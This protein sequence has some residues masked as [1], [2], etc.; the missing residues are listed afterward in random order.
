MGKLIPAIALLVSACASPYLHRNVVAACNEASSERHEI[1]IL[2][3]QE[4][5]A[6]DSASKSGYAG[7]IQRRQVQLTRKRSRC[8]S[9]MKKYHSKGAPHLWPNLAEPPPPGREDPY[10]DR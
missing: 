2:Q 9:L 3:A 5:M 1:S 10:R 6:A 8:D 7:E 4:G